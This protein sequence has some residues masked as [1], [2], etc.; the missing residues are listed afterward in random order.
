MNRL[1]NGMGSDKARV[2]IL[3]IFFVALIVFAIVY[4]PT[5]AMSHP[6]DH[7]HSAVSGK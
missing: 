7:S 6:A 5:N 4:R 3:L 2:L 1:G